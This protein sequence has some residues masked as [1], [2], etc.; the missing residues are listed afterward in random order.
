MGARLSWMMAMLAGEERSPQDLVIDA[1]G[2]H[3]KSFENFKKIQDTVFQDS[4][5]DS[6]LAIV[7]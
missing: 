1:E 2:G 4:V 6:N 3:G 7:I 5:L